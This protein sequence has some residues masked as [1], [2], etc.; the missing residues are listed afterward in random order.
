MRSCKM[1]SVYW[2]K[3]QQGMNEGSEH[4]ERTT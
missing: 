4:S 3:S 1:N 2:E